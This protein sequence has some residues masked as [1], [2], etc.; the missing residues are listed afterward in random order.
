MRKRKWLVGLITIILGI[1]VGMLG[2][3]FANPTYTGSLI[4]KLVGKNNVQTLAANTESTEHSSQ[5]TSESNL[6]GTETNN[7]QDTEISQ[8]LRQ[9]IIAD[10]K[11]DVGI[12]FDAWKCPDLPGFRVKLASGYTGEILEKHA[13]RAEPYFSQGIG[14]DVIKI[15]FDQIVIEKAD[16]STATLRVDYRYT[17]TDF[18]LKKASPIGEAHEQNV[19]ARVNLINVNSRWLIT[20]ESCL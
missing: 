3:S 20:G 15:D 17:A 16:K 19:H 7:Q 11:Q 13:G 2:F 8:Q 14:L 18:D 4:A 6:S 10:Y 5:E 9:K 12:F 1:T